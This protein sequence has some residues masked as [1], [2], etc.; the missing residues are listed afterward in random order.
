MRCRGQRRGERNVEHDLRAL[1]ARKALLD[2]MIRSLKEYGDA[3]Q[4]TRVLVRGNDRPWIKSRTCR[5]AA[6]LTK[7]I[8]PSLRISLAA[9]D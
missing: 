5:P 3:K 4:M 9:V 6:R 2:K 1:R 8:F 7:S